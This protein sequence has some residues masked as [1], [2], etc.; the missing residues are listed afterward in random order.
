MKLAIVGTRHE[1]LPRDIEA[2]IVAI[3]RGTDPNDVIVTGDCPTG[4]DRLVRTTA[5]GERRLVV[6][7][8]AWQTMGPSAGPRRNEVIADIADR[9]VAYPKFESPGTRHCIREFMKRAK[10]FE[11]QEITQPAKEKAP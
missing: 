7:K 1:P 4:V 10:P 8:A 2:R 11:F 3:I 9:L 5:D 6:C